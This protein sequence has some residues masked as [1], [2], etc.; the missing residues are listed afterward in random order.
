M[1]NLQ[2]VE[3]AF[4]QHLGDLSAC[5]LL[6]PEGVLEYFDVVTAEKEVEHYVIGLVE[7]NLR[8]GEFP[9]LRLLSHGFHNEITIKDFPIRGKACY[10]KVKRRRWVNEET[11]EF[12]SGNWNLVAGGARMTQEFAAFIKELHRQFRIGG[13]PSKL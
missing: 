9:K 11:G 6:L 10:Q 3:F 12:I 5:E 2:K 8:S 13:P 7:R 4:Q 1:W